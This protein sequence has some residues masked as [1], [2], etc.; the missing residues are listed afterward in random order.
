MVSSEELPTIRNI[1]VGVN[2]SVCKYRDWTIKRS[3]LNVVN[4]SNYSVLR[5]VFVYIIFWSGNYVNVTKIPSFKEVSKS[6][7]HFQRILKINKCDYKITI[8]NICASGKFKK[9]YNLKKLHHILKE[10]I[11]GRVKLNQS[12]FPALYVKYNIGTCIIFQN[13]KYTIVGCDKRKNIRTIVESICAVM[14]TR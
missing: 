1:K 7:K 9:D 8:H 4:H 5:D 6:V 11:K 14:N 12:V 13:G 10:H 3:S 2:I